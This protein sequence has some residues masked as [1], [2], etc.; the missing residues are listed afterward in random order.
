M[1]LLGS[2]FFL[3]KFGKNSGATDHQVLSAFDEKKR[4]QAEM[5]QKHGLD[6]R[7]YRGQFASLFYSA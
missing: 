2:L 1:Q 7:I 3:D 4:S 5:S 6:V